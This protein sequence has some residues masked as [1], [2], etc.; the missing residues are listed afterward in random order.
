MEIHNGEDMLLQG[1]QLREQGRTVEALDKL[2]QALIAFAQEQNYGRFAH[3]L[4]DR[5]ICWQHLYHVHGFEGFLNLFIKDAEAMLE[6]VQT[7]GIAE[8]LAGA[9]YMQA[10]ALLMVKNYPAAV[11]WYKQALEKVKQK[12][13]YGDWMSNLGKALYLSG[14]K[15]Q[16]V[17]VMLAGIKTIQEHAHEVDDYTANVWLSGGYLRLAE[18]L[19]T[20]DPSES[21][22][23]LVEA[24]RI[25]S[26][27]LKNTMREQQLE[28]F[29]KNGSIGI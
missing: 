28:L 20:D 12:S 18:A 2:H 21:E 22:H 26:A 10:K 19:K 15:E 23:Y 29:R 16:G 24:E 9:C 8:E 1:Q 14:D 3:T 5:A 7:H 6:L 25:I 17:K 4:L 11:V 27:H 13:Q